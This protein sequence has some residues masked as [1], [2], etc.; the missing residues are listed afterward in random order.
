M[1]AFDLAELGQGIL[2]EFVKPVPSDQTSP[3]TTSG[4]ASSHHRK[5]GT[6]D[7]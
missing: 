7:T 5:L 3:K 6:T 4:N 1:S 2:R